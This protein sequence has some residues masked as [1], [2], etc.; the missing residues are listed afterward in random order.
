MEILTELGIVLGLV[1]G[2]SFVM[3]TLRLPLLLGYLLAGFLAGPA[4]WGLLY[5]PESFEL[6]SQ[7]GITALLFIVGLGLNPA[8]IREAGKVSLYTGLGQIIVTSV[9]GYGLSRLFGWDVRTSWFLALGFTFSS[10]II[11]MKMLGDRQDLGRLYGKISIGLLLVQDLAATLILVVVTAVAQGAGTAEVIVQMLGRFI[12][13]LAGLAL[14]ARYLLPRLTRFFAA[15]QEFLLVFIVG[16]G[17]GISVLFARLGL[18]VEIGALAAGVA[19]ASSSYRYEMTAKMKLL[20]DF[21]LILFFVLLGSHLQISQIETLWA[22][23]LV[24]S[25]FVLIGNPLIVWAIMGVLGYTK[26]TTFMTGLSVA[27]V[28][29]FSLL[30]LLLVYKSNLVPEQALSLMMMVAVITFTGSTLLF[31]Q[32]DRLFH[33]LSPLLRFFERAH[34]HQ[35]RHHQERYDALLFGCHR[36]GED[37]I[38]TFQ[39]RKL[40]F[41]IVDFDPQV[42]AVLESKKIPCR[43]GDAYDNELMEELDP[44]HVKLLVC[45]IPDH[46]TN[47]FLLE[48][49]RRINKRA[50][51]ILTAHAVPEANALYKAGATY[52]IMPHYLGG[53]HAAMLVEKHGHRRMDF[54]KE[55]KEHLLHLAERKG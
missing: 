4:M 8:V 47:V 27:Q 38:K 43:Y 5:S 21:F 45:T 16:W 23:A 53:N 25:V 51:I 11:V 36:V 44:A 29:E 20:R 55:R 9:I 33:L 52:V 10:T 49:C 42:I 40:S 34:P 37:F 3:Q 1:V 48:K 24:F 54:S 35:E 28:S 31:Q 13:L 12:L 14:F 19:L 15:S 50:S 39:K 30:L 7:L 32:A 17:V 46:D 2:I 22:Q 41:L 18:S 6:F 26:R